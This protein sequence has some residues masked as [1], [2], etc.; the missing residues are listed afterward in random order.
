[1]GKTLLKFLLDENISPILIEKIKVSYP[2]SASSYEIGYEGKSDIE[3]YH[4]LRD[5]SYILITFDLDFTDIRKFPPEFVPGIIVLRFK[6]RK[7]QDI[8]AETMIYLE[9]LKEVDFEQALVIFQDTGIRIKKRLK[10][11]E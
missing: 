1:M 5:H 6:N 4:F 11:L 2:G 7:I 9:K 8:I 3:I 10:I